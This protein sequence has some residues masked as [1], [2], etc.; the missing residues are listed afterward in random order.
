MAA[1]SPL[2]VKQ[3]YNTICTICQQVAANNQGD[4]FRKAIEMLSSLRSPTKSPLELDLA[5]LHLG[6][7]TLED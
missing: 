4:Y 2:I 7:H 1:T 6:Y 3:D 5:S